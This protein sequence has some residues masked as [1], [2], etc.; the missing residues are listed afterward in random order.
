[1]LTEIERNP[2]PEMYVLR[3]GMSLPEIDGEKHCAEIS[4]IKLHVY[5]HTHCR[6]KF[7]PEIPP[8]ILARNST[9]NSM[10]SARKAH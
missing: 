6:P 4:D 3:L 9:R 2:L 10:L 1:M 8:E 5:L 7:L